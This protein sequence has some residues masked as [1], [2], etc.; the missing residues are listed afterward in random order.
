[1]LLKMAAETSPLVTG[2]DNVHIYVRE[3][4]RSVGFYR[5]ILGLPLKGDEHWME[6]DLGGVR[7]ALHEASP[8]VQELTSG[9]VAVNFRVADADEAASRISAAGFAVREQ[10]REEYGTSFEVVDPDGYLIYI[11]Q[12]PA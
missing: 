4:P 2:L 5:D 1:M 11:F 3:M 7:F 10:M 8:S 9:G 12:P 6:A